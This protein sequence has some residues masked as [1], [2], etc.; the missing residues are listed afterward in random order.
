MT[1]AVLA[2]SDQT[3]QNV[4]FVKEFAGQIQRY[5]F[6]TTEKMEKKGSSSWINKALKLCEE[7]IQKIVVNEFDIPSIE[8]KLQEYYHQD[9]TYFV[10]ITGGTK[11]MS[12]AINDFFKTK[13]NATIY[14]LTGEDNQMLNLSQNQKMPLKAAI[15]LE[16]YLTSY[17]IVIMKTSQMKPSYDVELSKRIYQE[18]VKE[19]E[20]NINLLQKLRDYVQS[21]ENKKKKFVELSVIEGLHDFLGTINFSDVQDKISIEDAKYLT[22]RWLEEY[23]YYH[24]KE[25]LQLSDDCIATGL[26]LQKESTKKTDNDFDLMFMFKNKLY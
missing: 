19:D 9:D 7:Q 22:G 13:P 8:T 5:W 1:I 24:V 23:T 12:L 20:K 21:K 15:S 11:L 14:Y 26:Y 17:G 4:Q 10:N 25:K 6:V 18:F 2:I 16:E 3:V